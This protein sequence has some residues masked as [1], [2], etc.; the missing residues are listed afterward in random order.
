M[1]IAFWLLRGDMD[2]DVHEADSSYVGLRRGGKASLPTKNPIGHACPSGGL[3]RGL[4]TTTTSS[5][6]SGTSL[7]LPASVINERDYA[8]WVGIARVL[9]R[10]PIARG[11]C[12]LRGETALVDAFRI[13]RAN[14][15]DAGIP[16]G[17]EMEEMCSRNWRI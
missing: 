6:V 2:F 9:S 10:C 14:L 7:A 15:P 4:S 16:L 11:H 12:S 3:R 17:A 5:S 1:I 8:K 13:D